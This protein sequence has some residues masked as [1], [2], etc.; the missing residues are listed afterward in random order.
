MTAA[1]ATSVALTGI[2]RHL[3]TVEAHVGNGTLDAPHHHQ[4]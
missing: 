2:R 4:R 3:V 1:Q